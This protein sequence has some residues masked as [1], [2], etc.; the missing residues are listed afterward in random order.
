MIVGRDKPQCRAHDRLGH[1]H[2]SLLLVT[3]ASQQHAI[4]KL[5]SRSRSATAWTFFYSAGR[6]TI[7]RIGLLLCVRVIKPRAQALGRRTKIASAPSPSQNQIGASAAASLS[8][9][10]YFVPW[11]SVKTSG[12]AGCRAAVRS[13]FARSLMSAAEPQT[14]QRQQLAP[15]SSHHHGGAAIDIGIEELFEARMARRLEH[16]RRLPAQHDT[17][18]I[19][20]N[21]AIADRSCE[22]DLV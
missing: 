11:T 4:S 8:Y 7:F 5:N 10:Q 2:G 13:T 12:Q 19:K 17:A 15:I 16:L 1:H 9:R 14:R 22:T 20:K 6:L 18:M 21:D 3:G